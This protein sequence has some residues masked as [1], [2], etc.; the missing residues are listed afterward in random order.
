M[1]DNFDAILMHPQLDMFCGLRETNNI[2]TCQNQ[3]WPDVLL[4]PAAHYV[5]L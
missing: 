1:Y 2:G 5:R 3:L 4:M